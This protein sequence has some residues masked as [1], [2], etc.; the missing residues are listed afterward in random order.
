M[1]S[2]VTKLSMKSDSFFTNKTKKQ[3]IPLCNFALKS[4]IYMISTN[5]Y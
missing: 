3:L 5:L 4:Y 1:I 2:K